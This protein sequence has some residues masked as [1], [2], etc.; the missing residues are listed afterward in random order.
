LRLAG[1]HQSVD[2][3]ASDR[4]TC[5]FVWRHKQHSSAAPMES[6]GLQSCYTFELERSHP[7]SSITQELERRRPAQF[8]VAS[9]G[10]GRLQGVE[11]TGDVACMMI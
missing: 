10:H 7:T 5:P 1:A 9:V 4:S 8:R 3:D 6:N 11:H 2:S